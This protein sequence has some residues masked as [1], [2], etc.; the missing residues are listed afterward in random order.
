MPG[1]PYPFPLPGVSN[2]GGCFHPT[3]TPTP[4]AISHD[5]LGVMVSRLDNVLGPVE[6]ETGVIH[7]VWVEPQH[8]GPALLKFLVVSQGQFYIADSSK[9]RIGPYV[10]SEPEVP[11]SN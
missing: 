5:V 1:D 9:V 11:E 7:G 4:G 10:P 3:P 8:F 2:I 6:F